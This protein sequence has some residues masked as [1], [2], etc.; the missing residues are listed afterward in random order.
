MDAETIAK[1]IEKTGKIDVSFA[2]YIGYSRQPLESEALMFMTS[3]DN[4][5]KLPVLTW[6]DGSLILA[7]WNNEQPF[8]QR[9]PYNVR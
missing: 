2:L 8:T 3:R 4:A 6:P 7:L 1:Q 5:K 9:R